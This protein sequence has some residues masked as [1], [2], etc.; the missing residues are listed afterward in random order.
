MKKT[1]IAAKVIVAILL[2]L[3]IAANVGNIPI[4]F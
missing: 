1:V 2:A 4:K 3:I